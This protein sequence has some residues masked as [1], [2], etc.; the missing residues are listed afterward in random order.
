MES[1][2]EMGYATQQQPNQSNNDANSFKDAKSPGVQRIEIVSS[3]Y[4]KTGLAFLYLSIFLVSYAYGLDGTIRYTYQAYATS[5][6]ATH[7]L[8]STVNVLRGV[9]GA[10]AQPTFARLSDVFGRFELICVTVVFYVIGTI[11]ETQSYEV[12]RFA[13][14][15]ILYQIGYTGVQLLIQVLIG[16]TSP[17]KARLVCSFV[18]TLPFLINTW[19][20][21]D[22][23]AATLKVTGW[24]WGIGMWAI[25]YP[26]V[27][28]PLL[29]SLFVM[30]RRAHKSGQLAEISTPFQR[31]SFGEKMRELFWLLDVIGIILLIAVFALILVPLT[32]AGGFAAKWKAAHILAPLI[33]GFLCLPLFVLWEMRAPHPIVPLHLLADRSIWAGLCIAVL[34]NFIWYCQ[35]G[36]LYTVLI[37]AFGESIKSA[38]RITS[39]YSFVSVLTGTLLGLL[40]TKVR[41][42]KPFIVFGTCMWLVSFGLLIRFRG[43]GNSHA[44][45]VAAQCLLGF[46]A[47]FFT[48]PTQTIVQAATRHEH[49]A[50]VT[51][52][53][54]GS[55]YIGS[56]FG[57]ALSGAIWSQVLPARLAME[58]APIN[59]TLATTVYGSPFTFI[60]SYPMGT[61]ER[62]AVVAAYQHVQRYLC[63]AGISLCIPLIFFACCLRNPTLGNEQSLVGAE[64]GSSGSSNGSV[65]KEPRKKMFGLF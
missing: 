10:A 64:N 20:S 11:I 2:T 14:G 22:V 12:Q 21:G 9:I 61:P 59:A 49:M 54:L 42:L 3:Q 47:G 26:I 52:L 37:V 62:M 43:G 27:I 15:A 60:V 44:G 41:K 45:V 50:V 7:S 57:N 56:A 65:T 36:F 31:L 51:G 24:S 8:L 63:I 34:I 30:N 32:L 48:F 53:Y 5:S 4:G 46:G 28:I 39:L 13:G 19:V 35:G 23:T 58:L 29:I 40:V 1:K 18:P 33:I 55:F 38:T 25:I 6:Y 16:D 17:L